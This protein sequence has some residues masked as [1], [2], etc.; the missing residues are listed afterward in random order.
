MTDFGLA[1]PAE[2]AQ[3]LQS[4]TPASTSL[5]EGRLTETGCVMGTPAYM[6]IEQHFGLPTDV[7]S[8]QFS[9]CVALYEGLYRVRPFGG[10]TSRELCIA[11][12]NTDLRTPRT[13][14]VPWH[15]HDAILRGLSPRPDERFESMGALMDALRPPPKRRRG[16][17]L[18]GLAGVAVGAL[19][20][21]GGQFAAEEIAPRVM[22]RS[23]AAEQLGPALEQ[24]ALQQQV[25]ARNASTAAEC[26][27]E[28][29]ADLG[30]R[31]LCLENV[32]RD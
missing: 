9:F 18:L 20:M 13:S 14:A 17:W 21:M 24:Q 29:G 15:L 11:I 32:R 6:P 26:E 27:A 10:A 1:V 5:G 8:D 16:G 23:T 25:V 30:V 19:S 7:R 31:M 22:D 4:I 3:T 12:R 28:F 2:M